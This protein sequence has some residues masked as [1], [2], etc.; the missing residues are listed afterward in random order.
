MRG[1]VMERPGNRNIEQTH[2]LII[3]NLKVYHDIHKTLKVVNETI[4]QTIYGIG[5]CY[6]VS[7]CADT[8]FQRVKMDWKDWK[9]LARA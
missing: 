9:Y 3:E 4:V 8:V 6:E 2:I 7:K 1:C 5:A